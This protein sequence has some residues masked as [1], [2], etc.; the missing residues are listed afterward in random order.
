LTDLQD[1]AFA[2]FHKAPG[3]MLSD[4]AEAARFAALRQQLFRKQFPENDPSAGR[5]VRRVRRFNRY[6][7]YLREEARTMNSRFLGLR[8]RTWTTG[9]ALVM[10][11][12]IFG[13][14]VGMR[15][16]ASA[17]SPT[18]G[19]SAATTPEANYARSLSKAFRDAAQ[20]VLP[21]VVMIRH[22]AAP[23]QVSQQGD[24][25][26]GG[27]EMTPFGDLQQLPPEFRRFFRGMPNMPGHGN[28]RGETSLGSG[29]IVD[30]SGIVVTNN[31][32]VDGDGKIV[33]RLQDGRELDVAE[34]KTDPKTDLAV[35]RLK[36]AG[37]LASVKFG[38]S[39]EIQVGDWVLALGDPFGLEGTVTAGIVSAKGRGLNGEPGKREDFIQ[40]D[41]AIN[42]G[43]SGGPLVD[44]DGNVIGINTAI[45]SRN[46][47]NQ[48]VGF[49]ISSQL[50]KWVT[51]NL[52]EHG[53]VRR[54]YLGVG[55]Q[56][57][58]QDI[59]NQLGVKARQGVVVADVGPKTP[60]A[61]AGLESGDI[62]VEFAGKAVGNPQELQQVV[63]Q[64]PI[65]SKQPL[66]VLR[67]GKRTNLEVKVQEQPANYGLAK[68]S[69]RGPSEKGATS[70]SKLGV[71]VAALT[72][73][74]AEKLGIEQKEGVVITD[75]RRGSPADL[76]GLSSGMVIVKVNQKLI[77]TPE[78]FQA[79]MEKSSVE[80][81][82]LLLVRTGQGTR[83]MVIRGS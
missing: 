20:K 23:Q 22:E 9:F 25:S 71:E 74:I 36:D 24:D 76:N 49:A 58:E 59:A 5:H 8:T 54:A 31:H 13:A 65:N 10:A 79:A 55:I 1:V 56:R 35:L 30:P 68:G 3:E 40:T 7:I 52:I 37:K 41:A 45:A 61:E 38:N 78:D 70:N 82:V 66:V 77:K 17:Q 15:D 33:V 81:G 12:A 53:S 4:F 44:L 32:V 75:V 46:G 26:E 51:D 28:P 42:P 69:M 57:I 39:D 72:P 14:A 29:V 48:G 80:K 2:A 47:G 18:A 34:V 67:D 16:H 11:A 6:P 19:P 63:E 43:N 27:L 64:S 83:F 21:A 60:A 62:I 73:E 50:A